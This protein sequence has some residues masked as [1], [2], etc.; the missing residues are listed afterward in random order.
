MKR[1]YTKISETKFLQCKTREKYI[2]LLYCLC[3]FHSVL[4][5]RKKFLM[6]GW[7]IGYE[8]NDSDFEAS[9][10]LHTAHVLPKWIYIFVVYGE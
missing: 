7:N 4:L 3:F 2:R 9:H 6:L 8:F 5:E 1:L 10:S